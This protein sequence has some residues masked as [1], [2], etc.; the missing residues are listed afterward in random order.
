MADNIP[1]GD[2]TGLLFPATYAINRY[3]LKRSKIGYSLRKDACFKKNAVHHEQQ[4]NVVDYQ[5]ETS[6]SI[7]T[8]LSFFRGAAQR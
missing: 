2:C 6:N 1:D 5:N 8:L 7:L 4:K 3:C